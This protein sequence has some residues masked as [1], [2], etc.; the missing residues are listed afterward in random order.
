MVVC[1]QPLFILN[2]QVIKIII[3][4]IN[5]ILYVIKLSFDLTD[6]SFYLHRFDYYWLCELQLNRYKF[7]SP[8]I[9][10]FK[11]SFV[12]FWLMCIIFIGSSLI[13]PETFPWV[14]LK[15]FSWTYPNRAYGFSSP[16]GLWKVVARVP[17][18]VIAPVDINTMIGF[19]KVTSVIKFWSC[20]GK[21]WIKGHQCPLG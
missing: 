17:V 20:V 16:T 18:F 7:L 3:M 8:S 15:I 11:L 5:A 4:R 13:Y 1:E 19:K 2:R 6:L 9:S 14:Y 12:Y 21:C 10:L